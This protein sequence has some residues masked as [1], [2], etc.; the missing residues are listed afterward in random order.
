MASNK[1][2]KPTHINWVINKFLAKGGVAID[3]GANIGDWTLPMAERA[4]ESGKIFSYEP[5]PHM[6]RALKKSIRANGFTNTIVLD[7]A[8]SN[9]N[10]TGQF[11]VEIGNSGG[12]RIGK[13]P[14]ES[15]MIDVNIVTL[16]DQVKK[17]NITKLDLL[18]IDVEGEEANVLEGAIPVI[19]QFKPACIVEIRKN[20]ALGPERIV[21]IFS[22]TGYK[23]IGIPTPY[24]IEECTT[25]NINKWNGILSSIDIVDFLFLPDTPAQ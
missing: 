23:L 20:C 22:S 7:T 16:A 18:K 9:Y 13:N 6:N 17:H 19:Q 3:V 24:G 1:L 8:C 12:S 4:D 2:F 5:I 25:Y 21:D 14:L 15:N 10:G 11:S